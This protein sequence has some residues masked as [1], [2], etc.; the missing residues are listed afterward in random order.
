[1]GSTTPPTPYWH[2]NVPPSL[3]TPECPEFLQ[4]LNAKD[5]GIVSTPD[6]AYS[7]Q[8]W[9]EVRAI[10]AS[11]RLELFQRV[12]SDLRRYLANNWRLRKEHGSVM[13]FVLGHRL[14][15]TT[16]IVAKGRPFECEEDH[17][18]LFNDWPYGIDPRIV[19]LVVWTKFVLEEDPAT[20]DL[21]DQARA[22]IEAFVTKTF[23]GSMARDRVIW[24]K[25]WASLKS[26]HAVEH[27]HVMLFD[28]DPELVREVTNGDIPTSKW[29][30]N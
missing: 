26:I 27:F 24:F 17:K 4:N 8:P 5:L 12:P 21:T 14:G 29:E 6:A 11:N 3:R 25:N 23:C 19:H 30:T 18:I 9:S 7:P 22:E 10:I 16:P 1:M 15:W 13:N 2:I 20:G 28:P